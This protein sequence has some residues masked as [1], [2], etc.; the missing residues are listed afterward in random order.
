MKSG[1]DR[2]YMNPDIRPQ[3]DLFG[4]VN[5]RWVEQTEI[6][7]DRARYGTFYLLRDRSEELLRDIIT[8]AAQDEGAPPGS[9]RRKVGDLFTSFMDDTRVNELGV[10]PLTADLAAI[11]AV[12][13][14]S[15]LLRVLGRLQRG[16]VD[17]LFHLFVTSDARASQN[18]VVYVHQGGL[19]LPDESYYRQEDHA[20][21]RHAY[22]GHIAAMLDLAGIDPGADA[23][24]RIMAL[25]TR[26][27]AGHWDRVEARDAVKSYTKLDRVALTELTPGLDWDAWIEGMQ[28]PAGAFSEVIGRQPSFLSA[29]A[30][31]LKEVPLEDWRLWLTWR[32]LSSTA[33]YLHDELVA[34]D[35]DFQGRTL[36][37]APENRERWKRGVGLV[38]E[39]LG[40]AAGQLYVERHFPPEAKARMVEL[41][42]NVVEAFRR[43]LTSL[44]WMGSE[45]RRRALDKLDRFLPKIGYPDVWRD[46]TAYRVAADDLVGN[47]RR[48]NAFEVD[49]QLA[50]IGEPI[51]RTEWLMTPQTVNAYYHP[52]MNEIVFPA[53][54]LQ[55]PFFDAD[56]DDAV[57]YGGIGAVIAH[58]IGH[59]FDDQGSRYDGSG[60]LSDWWTEEDRGR[61]D[62]LAEKLITQFSAYESRQ[63]PGHTVNGALTVGENI[64]DLGGLTIGYAAYRIAGEGHGGEPPEIDG[65]TGD[66][67]FFLG[68]AQVWKG[69]ARPEEAKRLL[70]VDPHAPVELR[71]NVVRNLAEFHDAFG[72][73][74]GDGLWLDEQE[75]VRIFGA[76]E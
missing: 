61:F 42:D 27:A 62:A 13:D 50:K 24:E 38:E 64:G 47:V 44:A 32:L 12:T 14:S 18:Y 45:T 67:R 22:V 28:A 6:P 5:G 30:E 41:V 36:S 7:S 39:L 70:A 58:E 55:P 49:R 65:F 17:G 29:A 54:I 21:I 60:N 51:D 76:V 11:G 52:G 33:P 46:Y 20:E 1:I 8:E 26:L 69:K 25:E 3:D 16:G 37:G 31:A 2:E 72:V 4:H 66:Q 74:E 53:A 43:D 57:N 34:G 56:A 73:T 71:A 75:R 59:G 19:G 35:F 10:Q 63:A 40:E 23:A 9:P 15:E 48:G 68:W